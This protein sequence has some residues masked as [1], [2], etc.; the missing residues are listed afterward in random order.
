MRR[1][2]LLG[3]IRSHAH[4]VINKMNVNI[5][6]GTGYTYR[7]PAF[8][9]IQSQFGMRFYVFFHF[10]DAVIG[11]VKHIYKYILQANGAGEYRRD[12]SSDVDTDVNVLEFIYLYIEHPQ[13]LIQGFLQA[14]QRILPISFL[15][16][17]AADLVNN[18]VPIAGVG[19]DHIDDFL[20]R[21]FGLGVILKGIHDR[22]V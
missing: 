20:K 1:K 17:V 16:A 15:A 9:V 4:A 11:I 12:I 5:A 19:Y 2:E 3:D 18:L 8:V 13:R 10:L 22:I 6:F 7:N 21:G 14:N